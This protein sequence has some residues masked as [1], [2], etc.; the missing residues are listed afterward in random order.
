MFPLGQAQ[1]T[2]IGTSWI[3]ENVPH[4]IGHVADK[5]ACQSRSSSLSLS[6]S[7]YLR[8]KEDEKTTTKEREKKFVDTD[9][10]HNH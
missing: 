6:L 10:A 7:S 3:L 9:E 5:T 2:R 4:T 8:E 1:M